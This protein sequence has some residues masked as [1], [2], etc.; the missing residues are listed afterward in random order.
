MAGEDNLVGDATLFEPENLS[1]LRRERGIGVVINLERALWALEYTAQ[2]GE[3]GLD[4]VLKGGTAVQLVTDPS[5]PRFSVDVDICT[6]ATRDELEEA[7]ALVSDGFE[8]GFE[9]EPRK[10]SRLD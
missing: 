4:F 1:R 7:L 2:L 5:W 3:A 8:P 9:Y 6:D 10:S